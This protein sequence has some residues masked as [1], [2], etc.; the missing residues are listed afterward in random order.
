[1]SLLLLL[2]NR[3]LPSK[4]IATKD[5]NIW[6]QPTVDADVGPQ[7]QKSVEATIQNQL[8]FLMR[9]TWRTPNPVG[10]IMQYVG[11]NAPIG[12]LFCDGTSY[13]VDEYSD[14]FAIIGTTYGNSGGTFNVPNFAG[15]VPVG[16]G[17][18]PDEVLTYNLGNQGGETNH[19]LSENEMPTHN[20]T[21]NSS[22]TLRLATFDGNNTNN[23]T[24]MDNNVNEVNLTN[25]GATLSINNTGGNQKHNNM[26]PY[27]VVR[28]II[29]W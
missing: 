19:V 15:R 12:W 8:G 7:Q 13:S 24:D 1:M 11:I 27:V 9:K 17:D 3:T 25:G 6:D 14:L 4:S 2:K 16:A 18:A 20:H 5:F 28:Y 22:S 26:Q 21:S 10:C 23:G 29:K